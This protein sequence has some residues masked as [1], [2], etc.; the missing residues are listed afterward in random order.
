MGRKHQHAGQLPA[1]QPEHLPY[2]QVDSATFRALAEPATPATSATSAYS[3]SHSSGYSSAA[4]G[5]SS[6]Y[7]LG[8]SAAS[9]SSR[10]NTPDEL[11]RRAVS[12]P[13]ERSAACIPLSFSRGARGNLLP[14]PLEPS[15]SLPASFRTTSV[16][17]AKAA[18]PLAALSRDTC[19]AAPVA[20]A[21]T[22]TRS[23]TQRSGSASQ[24]FSEAHKALYRRSPVAVSN[25]ID[26]GLE[27]ASRSY[28]SG[29]INPSASASIPRS[30]LTADSTQSG[31]IF[32]FSHSSSATI[33]SRPSAFPKTASS[34][35]EQP[36]ARSHVR[37]VRFADEGLP[38][39]VRTDGNGNEALETRKQFRLNHPSARTGF[40]GQHMSVNI[41]RRW[42]TASQSA[43]AFAL[44]PPP[45]TA[46]GVPSTP[47]AVVTSVSS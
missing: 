12:G 1:E 22:G 28:M 33:G 41:P 2:L 43:A 20:R 9:S 40:S 17:P 26:T 21:T 19:G 32:P 16:L 15:A 10:R 45:L 42:A 14:S 13:I 44:P 3:S 47:P 5:Y 23:A 37:R 6:A 34:G 25:P 8:H 7:S 4:F 38:G 29:P 36:S 27:A 24:P 11:S 31:P 30:F 18:T 46:A 39:D 35:W